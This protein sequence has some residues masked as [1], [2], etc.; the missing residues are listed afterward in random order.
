MSIL[1]P[2][3]FN[4]DHKLILMKISSPQSAM[5]SGCI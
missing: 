3:R 5:L 4:E 2:K 1:I